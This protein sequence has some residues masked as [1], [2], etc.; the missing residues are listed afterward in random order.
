MIILKVMEELPE[1]VTHGLTAAP[2]ALA[3]LV[4]GV[5]PHVLQEKAFILGGKSVGNI[6]GI[7]YC[8]KPRGLFCGQAPLYSGTVSD[9]AL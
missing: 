2:L 8:A 6:P 3:L 5:Q 4:Q 7:F 1:V 9:S